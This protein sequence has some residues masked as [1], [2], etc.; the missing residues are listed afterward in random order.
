MV[1]YT[2]Q[3]VQQDVF[4]QQALQKGYSVIK[5]ETLVDAAFINNM[6]MK[7][8]DLVFVRVD[9]DIV[10]NLIDKN[11]AVESVLSKDEADALVKLFN[12]PMEGLQLNVEVK[13]LSADSVPV[14]ATR[15]EL[16]RRMKDMAAM[17]GGMGAWYANMPDEV[18]LTING[19][20]GRAH[21]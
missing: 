10:D 19:K 7:W 20:I 8:S 9:A 17:G 5:M 12:K 16:M 15:P 1:V 14:M 6:E 18:Q 3:P 21:V 2:T 13:G 4:I 11:D